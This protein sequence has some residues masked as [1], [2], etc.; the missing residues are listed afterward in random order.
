MP[1]YR[2]TLEALRR[3]RAERDKAKADLHRSRIEQLKLLRAQRKADRKET[4]ENTA[5]NDQ[6]V[7]LRKKIATLLDQLREIAAKLAALEQVEHELQLG[8]KSLE[9]LNA[10]LKKLQ[11][12]LAGSRVE[13]ER[14]A[15]RA[16]I[17][18]LQQKIED[19]KARLAELT[20]RLREGRG[21]QAD[22]EAEKKKVE[23]G[24]NRLQQELIRAAASTPAHDDQSGKIDTIRTRI[25]EEKDALNEKEGRVRV[26]IDELFADRSPQNL[27]EEWSDATPIMLLPL[28]IETRFKDVDGQTEL[29]V[30]VFP[31][32]IAV[33]THEKILPARESTQGIAC[34]KA[35]RS[36]GDDAARKAAWQ[37][38]ADRFG[39]NRAA[40]VALQTKPL[41]WTTPPPASDDDLQYPEIPLTKP[42]SWS[43]AP[44]SLV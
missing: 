26:L 44:H 3:A 2:E 34:W 28:R 1:S 29:W 7:D 30:R 24:I 8:K 21:D 14:A 20:R 5:A 22:L 32:E 25:P 39:A 12:A 16:E 37:A 10:E 40:W 42:D 36:A 19:L 4:V 9:T 13:S 35:L 6:I 33:T 43:E 41:N 31:D 23:A 18:T 15:L 38:L 27:I 11:E 17:E